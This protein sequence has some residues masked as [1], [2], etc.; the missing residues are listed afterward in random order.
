MQSKRSLLA[1]SSVAAAVLL[2]T[3]L[4]GCGKVPP[5]HGVGSSSHQPTG[6]ATAG[7][8]PSSAS[9]SNAPPATGG[10]V[11]TPSVG[12]GATDVQ[13]DTILSVNASAGRLSRVKLWHQVRDK[14]GTSQKVTVPG[15]LNK[16][17]S[18]WTAASAL[19]PD[20]T[21][22]LV[23]EGH[24]DSDQSTVTSESSFTTERLGLDEQTY[25]TIFPKK[26]DTV[27]VGMPVVLTFDIAVL[28]RREFEKH[29]HVTSIPHQDG[30]WHWYGDREVHFRPKS[31]WQPGTKVEVEANLNGVSAGGGIYGQNSTSTSFTIGRSVVTNLDLKTKQARVYINGKFARQIPVSGGKPGWVSRSGSKLIMDKMLTHRMT[32]QMIGARET[33]DLN[34]KYAIRVTSSGEFLHA[35]PWNKSKFG[36][37][38]ASHGCIG[39]STANAAWLYDNVD[40]GDPVITT[41]TTRR[42]EQGNG[43]A[44]WD[45]S[46]QQYQ[47]GS[48]L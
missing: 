42:L 25:P 29:L 26:G 27:G 48:A 31:Y 10:V 46:Y 24:N 21:Y 15:A 30:S 5:Q 1:L 12:D 47:K 2:A 9:A 19:D 4:T 22:R 32:N 41:G 44:D 14:R 35:A 7:S 33:Y 3:T 11:M 23:M 6:A 18:T 13:V 39:M 45:I 17:G 43:W 37:V 16:D 28:D 36:R 38:N 20:S 34:V 40:I 8:Q